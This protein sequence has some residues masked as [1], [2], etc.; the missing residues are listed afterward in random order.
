MAKKLKGA[1]EEVKKPLAEQDTV[2]VKGFELLNA[3]KIA[4]ALE[5]LGENPSEEALLAAYDK[6][7]G[8]IRKDGRLIATGTFWDFDE[9]KPKEV[10]DYSKLGED[11]FEDEYVLVRKKR[12]PKAEEK[13]ADVKRKLSKLKSVK[14]YKDKKDSKADDAEE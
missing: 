8:A 3:R 7:A 5:E 11:D 1:E 6:R 2:V 14:M 9:K 10:K 12:K 13:A 4:Q